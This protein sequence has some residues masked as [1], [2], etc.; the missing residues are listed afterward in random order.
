MTRKRDTESCSQDDREI[1][2]E[3]DDEECTEEHAGDSKNDKHPEDK[4]RQ[5]E[6]G[7]TCTN[8]SHSTGQQEHKY[9]S[10][11]SLCPLEMVSIQISNKIS[12]K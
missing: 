7:Q 6:L 2:A 8:G 9:Q 5:Y 11:C 12:V 10:H 1:V 3:D 4:S